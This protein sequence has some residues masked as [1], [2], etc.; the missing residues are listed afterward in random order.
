MN[1]TPLAVNRRAAARMIGIGPT[2]LWQETYPRGPIPCFRIGR[3]VR[4]SVDDLRKYVEDQ[5][6]EAAEQAAAHVDVVT[7]VRRGGTHR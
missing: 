2:K 7:A 5:R 6:R 1:E 3:A 4:Y